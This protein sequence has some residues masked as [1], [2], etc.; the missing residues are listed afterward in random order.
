MFG[1]LMNNYYYGKSGK[2]DFRKEDMP[3]NRWQLFWDTLRTRLSALFRLNLMYAVI[4][5][6]A[7]IVI[8]SSFLN[9]ITNT[10]TILSAR[11]GTLQ[12]QIEETAG[13]ENAVSYTDEEI[14]N[15]AAIN[16]ADYME[17]LLYRML[18]LLIPCIAITGPFTAGVS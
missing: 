11:D 10:S 9:M 14:A 17:S 8:T 18:L 12:T 5:L 3:E 15:L 2:G 6:P 1:R 16:P 7:I 13:E 4:W